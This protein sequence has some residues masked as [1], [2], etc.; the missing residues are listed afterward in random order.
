MQA[1]NQ[2][3]FSHFRRSLLA[4]ACDDGAL[5]TWDSNTKTQLRRFDVGAG[6]HSAPCTGL[7]FSPCN[8]MLLASVG[9]DANII[10]YDV[11]SDKVI[12]SMPTGDALSSVDL[13]SDGST[14]VVGSNRGRLLV[15]DFRKTSEPVSTVVAHH[16]AISRLCFSLNFPSDPKVSL[17]IICSHNIIHDITVSNVSP[18]GLY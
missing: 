11:V 1:L 16:S 10:C 6:G 4:G 2:I 17:N 9:L 18:L 7:V 13:L 5:Y 8:H 12:K 3:Q 15:F 14:I